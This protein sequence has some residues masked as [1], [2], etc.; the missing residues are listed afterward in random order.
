MSLESV[1]HQTNN[2]IQNTQSNFQ[3]LERC[4]AEYAEQLEKEIQAKIDSIT[5]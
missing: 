2:T 5:R 1:Y 4:A 3:E